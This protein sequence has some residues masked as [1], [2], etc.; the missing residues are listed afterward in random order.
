MYDKVI[1]VGIVLYKPNYERLSESLNAIVKQF[2]TVILYNNGGCDLDR[3]SNI[4][5]NGLNI[6]TLGNGI[7]IGISAALNSIMGEAMNQK[8]SWVITL[9]Q[10]SVIP[11]NMKNEYE[12]LTS[13]NNIGIICPQCIDLRRKYMK[14]VDNPV[15]E[16]ISM[17]ITS[18][19]CT[20]CE[21]WQ[22]I[23]KFDE[24]LFIDLVDNDYCKRII[25]GG[26][27][28]IKLNSVILN[29]Q[30]GDIEARPKIIENFFL[31]AGKILN[32]E[33]VAK[34]SFKRKVSPLRIYYE[35]RNIIYLNKKYKNYG[36]IGY[37]NH[38]CKTYI[39]FQ[40]VFSLYSLIVGKEKVKIFGAIISGIS[41]GWHKE[42][43]QW[44]NNYE[45]RKNG[46]N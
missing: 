44:S 8:Y 24:W 1:T 17:C 33:N 6:I 11:N 26:Y 3:I 32:S 21:I 34:L 5:P 20:N 12:K 25:L 4:K 16:K 28:I 43:I 41:D 45:Q 42:V 9:D 15:E 40:I 38:H 31:K 37:E 46:K 18:G 10:D 2:D 35:N 29:H 39:G 7:N 30:Y 22:K 19:S 36:G 23:G 27:D 13:K 14:I